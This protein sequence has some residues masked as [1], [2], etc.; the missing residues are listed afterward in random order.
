[1]I[2]R[3]PDVPSEGQVQGEFY[4][5]CRNANIEIHLE[6]FGDGHCRFDGVIV[7]GNA[8]V[9]II[10]CKRDVPDKRPAGKREESQRQRYG[11]FGVPVVWVRGMRG[12][13]AAFAEVRRIIA[14][15]SGGGWRRDRHSNGSLDF[16][17]GVRSV[18]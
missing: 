18:R 6:Y 5:R 10:E 14:A 7:R 13:E 16:D 15:R 8:I 3:K 2:F 11:S 9:A 4:R 1:M 12:I 17:P